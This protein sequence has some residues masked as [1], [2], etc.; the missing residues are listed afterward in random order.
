MAV[1]HPLP[2]AVIG[3]SGFAIAG[4]PNSPQHRLADDP[5]AD[6]IILRRAG[7]CLRAILPRWT[8]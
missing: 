1:G 5:E 8:G 6:R 3:G 7:R 4:Q 2:A